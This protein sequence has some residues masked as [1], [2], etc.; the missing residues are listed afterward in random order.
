[1]FKPGGHGAEKE[2]G[3]QTHPNQVTSA[4]KDLLVFWKAGVALG[5]DHN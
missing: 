3:T 4:R 2:T 1:M 5:A